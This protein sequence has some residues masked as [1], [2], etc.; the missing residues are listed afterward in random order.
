MSHST[1]PAAEFTRRHGSAPA[2]RLLPGRQLRNRL[3]GGRVRLPD[4]LRIVPAHRPDRR[5]RPVRGVLPRRRP[6]A[7][8]APRP[9]ARARRRRPP[10][11]ADRAGRPRRRDHQHRPGRNPEHHLQRPRGPGAPALH[12]G[13]ALRRPRGL[14][15][16]HHGQRLDRRQLPPRRLPGPRGP[17]HPRRGLRGNR[18]ADLGRVGR[19]R[20]RGLSLRRPVVGGGRGPAGAPHRPALHRGRHPAAAAQRPVPAGAVPGRRFARGPGLRRPAGGRHLL[21]APAARRRPGVPPRH[22]GAHA[23]GRPGRQRREDHARQRVHPRRHAA[24]GPREEGLGPQP[25]DRPAAGHRVPRAVLGPGAAGLRSRRP[26]AGHRPRGGRNLRN[27]RQR[28]PRRQGPPAGRPV[29]GRGQGEGPV[30]P[31]VR[32]GQDQPG[33]LHL[34]RLVHRGRG[35]A[36]RVCPDRRRRRLQHL[37][38]AHPVRPRRHRQP[39]RAGTAGARR[40]PHGV[41][42]Q[43]AAGEPRPGHPGPRTGAGIEAPASPPSRHRPDDGSSGTAWVT[44][45][46]SSTATTIRCSTVWNSSSRS[47][48][49]IPSIAP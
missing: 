4:R 1:H 37:A 36:D 33:R 43:H 23:P 31:P 18:Q 15:H 21:R 41:R 16:R 12:A 22:R 24:G 17:V 20:H 6:A 47:G 7:A 46:D 25:A 40:V 19:R 27:P 48:G 11:R 42:G 28:L 49:V 44:A 13:P 30:H 32:L 35:P 26:A 10:R 2:G 34:H 14:E 45:T 5:A 3:E 39:P 38:V 8:R 29:A 9:P